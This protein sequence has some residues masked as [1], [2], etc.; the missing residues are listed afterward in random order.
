MATRE[1]GEGIAMRR[2]FDII[3]EPRGD[4][5]RKLMTAAAQLSSGLVMVLRDDLGLGEAGQA[6]LSRL[7]PSLMGRQR[8]S[9]WPGTTL[10]GEAATILRFALSAQVLEEVVVASSGLFGWQQ[11]MLPEDLAL[12]RSDGTAV[13]ASICH[14]HDAYFE[15]SD[16]EYQRLV[17]SVPEIAQIA[18]SRAD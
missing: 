5:L 1:P 10:L 18:R 7:Q 6:L 12:I 4:L 13:L 11:P 17:S 14:E 16:A 3:E 2:V 15:V 8:G 9:R